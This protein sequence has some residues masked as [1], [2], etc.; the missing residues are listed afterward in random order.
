M[1]N[2]IETKSN[3]TPKYINHLINETSPYL[4]DH[5]HNPVDWYPWGDDAF[6]K[7]KSENKL[8]FLSI[9]YHACHWCHVMEKESFEDVEV[10]EVLNAKYICIKVDREERKDLDAI[11]MKACQLMTGA[12]GWP[13]N[14]WLTPD[15]LPIYAGT[16]FPKKTV[17]NRIGLIEVAEFLAKTFEEES[18][19]IFNKSF[20]IIT[21]L[22][23]A[24]NHKEEKLNDDI[25]KEAYK[26]L[27]R[28]YDS[29]FGGFSK[30]P[31]F[32]VVSQLMFLLESE[33]EDLQK[34][35]ITSLKHMIRGGIYDHI[36]GGFSRY[37]VDNKWLIPHFEKMLYDNGQLL[38]VYSKAYSLTGFV[39]FKIVIQETIDFLEKELKHPEGGF[40]SA[41]DADSEGVEGKFYRFSRDEI[42][43][44]LGVKEAAKFNESYNVTENGN[45][46]GYN[47]VN[48]I[49]QTLELLE[50]KDFKKLRRKLYDYREKRVKPA[51]D[52]K[53]LAMSNG[54]AIHGLLSAYKGIGSEK[55]LKLALDAYQYLKKYLITNENV[56]LSSIRNNQGNI[57]GMIDDYASVIAAQ[58]QLYDITFDNIYLED[59]IKLT[60]Q[61][62]KLFY[63]NEHGGFFV[64]SKE[65][66]HLIYN[67]KEI[68]DGATPSGNSMMLINLLKLFLLTEKIEYKKYLDEMIEGFSHHWNRYKQ[69][70]S[71][72]MRF[73]SYYLKGSIELK[74]Y[75]PSESLRSEGV[76]YLQEIDN[77]PFIKLLEVKL[78]KCLEGLPTLYRCESGHC[79]RPI[80]VD[81]K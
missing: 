29:D 75:L 77:K 6:E 37:S 65:N 76:R 17:M 10:A 58:L 1:P 34:M 69:Y 49:G 73:I 45:F 54:F 53:I 5:A 36:G 18:N 15:K 21:K 26:G 3:R 67:P 66:N 47:I 8:I 14:L 79:E 39:A 27:E 9:G 12:G 4:L 11:Y 13:M 32:P 68:Y 55:A 63:D 43:E 78:E 57:E 23:R 25:I 44:V 31:K 48:L 46:E 40:Y 59:A 33:Q 51:L 80:N 72:S 24:E 28:S 71:E 2:N 60:Q 38:D 61:S 74:L 20:E 64:G 70:A 30:A 7:A 19:T 41:F 81:L 50:D 52:D 22:K 62:I 16:Y 56:L 35:A 42:I